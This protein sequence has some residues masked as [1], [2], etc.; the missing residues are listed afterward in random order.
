MARWGHVSVDMPCPPHMLS[1]LLLLVVGPGGPLREGAAMYV[2]K[3]G[4]LAAKEKVSNQKKEREMRNYTSS[5]A[6]GE[7]AQR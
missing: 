7:Q 1:P 2:G 5:V 6:R 4:D 3:E